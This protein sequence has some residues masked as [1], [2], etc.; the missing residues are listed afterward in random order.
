MASDD[1]TDPPGNGN[2]TGSRTGDIAAE[3]RRVMAEITV[4]LECIAGGLEAMERLPEAVM[5]KTQLGVL[6]DLVTLAVQAVEAFS[7]AL[8]TKP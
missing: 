3:A 5:V 1:N 7:E 4:I 2:S 6:G 8:A